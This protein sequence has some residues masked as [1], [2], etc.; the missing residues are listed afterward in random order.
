MRKVL[1]F[2]SFLLIVVITP[3]FSQ[4]TQPIFVVKNTDF[5]YEDEG[6]FIFEG[7]LENSDDC[8]IYFIEDEELNYKPLNILYKGQI[9]S[10]FPEYNL[11][12]DKFFRDEENIGYPQWLPFSEQYSIEKPA[13]TFDNISEGAVQSTNKKTGRCRVGTIT[14]GCVTIEYQHRTKTMIIYFSDLKVEW[15]NKKENK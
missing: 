8:G 13:F 6:D 11:G 7:E 9:I 4:S 2:L 3:I 10:I 15:K 5:Q 14:S 1:L 12:V